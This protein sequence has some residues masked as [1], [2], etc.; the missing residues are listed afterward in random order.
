[1]SFANPSAIHPVL[2]SKH[3]KPLILNP[4]PAKAIDVCCLKDLF[5]F[6]PNETEVE[7]LGGREKLL[8]QV[9]TLLVTLGGDGFEIITKNT[10]KAYPC[11]KITPV[12]TTAA[13]D[14]LCGGLVAMLA[15]GKALEEAAQFG[16]KAA[17]IA[18]TRK[19]AQQSIPTR[20][21]VADFV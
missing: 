1:M 10:K 15:E 18:C 4:A 20:E 5:L 3:H 2:P 7:L 8:G 9:N 21:E 19:G 13:G 6:T 16:S 11:I 12:D 17:S 14:T